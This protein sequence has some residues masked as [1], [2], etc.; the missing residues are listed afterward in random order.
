LWEAVKLLGEWAQGHVQHITKARA[1]FDEKINSEPIV[2]TTAE[3]A[4]K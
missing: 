2:P 3:P 4:V 1:A